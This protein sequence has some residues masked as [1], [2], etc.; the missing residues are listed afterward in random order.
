MVALNFATLGAAVASVAATAVTAAAL[1]APL[2]DFN[3]YSLSS[4]QRFESWKVHFGKQYDSEESLQKAEDA[5]NFND[6]FIQEHN[7]K[8]LSFTVAHNK[9]SDLKWE[10]F[11]EMYTGMKDRESYL[12]RPK[13]Y[14]TKRG[15]ETPDSVDWVLKNAVT[16]IKDQAQC[17]S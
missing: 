15:I 8:G 10:E 3:N 14:V 17:G 4:S 13:K 1:E 2:Q 11:R 5:W 16:P 9:F 12:N 6:R 7:T